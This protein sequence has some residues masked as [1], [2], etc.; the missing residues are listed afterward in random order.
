MKQLILNFG[1]FRSGGEVRGP[2]VQ[3]QG[4]GERGKIGAKR[5]W[6]LTPLKSYRSVV[7]LSDLAIDHIESLSC[8]PK[9]VF[10]RSSYRNWVNEGDLRPTDHLR[11][12]VIILETYVSDLWCCKVSILHCIEDSSL[13]WK[14]SFK[15]FCARNNWNSHTH[16]HEHIHLAMHTCRHIL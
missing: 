7:C 13:K 16:A 11:L 4:G 12:K 1:W 6:P 8:L 15:T 3:R 5:R 14:W 9:T 2:L 10:R